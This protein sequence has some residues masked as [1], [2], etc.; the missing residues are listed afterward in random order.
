MVYSLPYI[1]FTALLAAASLV[2]ATTRQEACKRYATVF[3]VMLFFFFLGFR[4][5][6][7]SDWINYYPYF[8]DCTLSDIFDFGLASPSGRVRFE[9][10][11]T[12]LCLACRGIVGDYHFFVAVHTAIT[13]ALFLAFLRRRVDNIPFAL[14]LFCSFEGF[15]LVVNLM[16]N[17]ISIMIFLNALQFIEKRRPLPYFLCCLVALSFHLSSVVYFPLYFFFHRACN[18]WVYLAIFLALNAMFLGNV[19]IVPGLCALL[20]LDEMM[21]QKIK[22]YTEIYATNRG[23]SIGYLERLFTG[24]LVFL[25][26]DSLRGLR[27]DSAVRLNGIIAYYV[28]F[29]SLSEFAELSQRMAS[30]FSYGY[31]IVWIDLTHCFAIGNNRRLFLAY[32]YL[33]C[34][35][36]VG[37]SCRVPDCD[38]ENI[39]FGSQNYQERL[40]YHNKTYEGE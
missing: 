22:T 32:L 36:R 19:S 31:W 26:Y 28:M 2:Y 25:Y 20:G 8:Y 18:K 11:F 34:L 29:F 1:L 24:L 3:A 27:K 7:L 16:R 6:I 12:L 30:L 4:G 15:V 23:I 33:Y 13:L 14:F 37:L 5:F 17:V 38:Y 9:P 21:A 39:L 10:G 35:L 40:L